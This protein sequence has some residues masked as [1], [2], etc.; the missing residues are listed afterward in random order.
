MP[1]FSATVHSCIF[2]SVFGLVRWVLYN[3]LHHDPC[4]P[5]ITFVFPI[6]RSVLSAGNAEK[7][8]M[9]VWWNECFEESCEYKIRHFGELVEIKC[10]ISNA[11][12]LR[13]IV[14]NAEYKRIKALEHCVLNCFFPKWMAKR[15]VIVSRDGI[16]GT[17]QELCCIQRFWWKR[18]VLTLKRKHLLW[19]CYCSLSNAENRHLSQIVI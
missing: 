9:C 4:F 11:K 1:K 12:S 16:D 2:R 5:F 7:C 14:E 15:W 8:D 17:Q 13:S 10:C 19:V 6:F 3:I 18:N